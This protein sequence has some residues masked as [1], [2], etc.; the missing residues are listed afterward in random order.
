MFDDYNNF[1]K[2]KA[3]G[4]V[5]HG[6]P[7]E[8]PRGAG[9]IVTASLLSGIDLAQRNIYIDDRRFVLRQS[10]VPPKFG[11]TASESIPRVLPTWRGRCKFRAIPSRTAE[12]ARAATPCAA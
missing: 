4:R 6:L 5:F 7:P 10:A 12:R 11:S 8:R 2:S 3:D 9:S 1:F